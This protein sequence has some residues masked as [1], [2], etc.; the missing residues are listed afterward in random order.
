VQA[1]CAKAL[2]ASVSRRPCTTKKE[3]P[4]EAPGVE[5][6]YCQFGFLTKNK[7]K[8]QYQYPVTGTETATFHR[9][10][11]TS[12]TIVNCRKSPESMSTSSS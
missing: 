4:G 3:T 9:V 11:G 2:R 12:P 1:R 8:T 5:A 6:A 7:Q 10:L